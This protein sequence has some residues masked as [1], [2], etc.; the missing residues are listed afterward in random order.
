MM[1]K[2]TLSAF[3]MLILV[4]CLSVAHAQ[5]QNRMTASIPFDFKIGNK[6]LPAGEYTI[7]CVNSDSGKSALLLK[8]VDGRTSR[9]VMMTPAQANEAQA[10]IRIVFNRYGNQYFLA[11]VWTTADNYGLELARSRTERELAR[12]FQ[13]GDPERKD[14][15]RVAV[16]L[17]ATKR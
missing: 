7:Q 10:Q 6:S 5:F 15:E 8:S 4:T 9:M 12:E 2:L 16:A 11:Q 14:A 17:T 3:V 1:K 13:K